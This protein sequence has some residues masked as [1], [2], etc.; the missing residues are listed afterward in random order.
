MEAYEGRQQTVK[1]EILNP[2]PGN[3]RKHDERQIKFFRES[4]K[5][6]GQTRPLLVNVQPVEGVENPIIAGNGIYEAMRREGWDKCEVIWFDMPEHEAIAES[7]RDN[8]AYE[9][10]EI[11][12]PALVKQIFQLEDM[13]Y[14]TEE[15]GLYPEEIES[16]KAQADKGEGGTEKTEKEVID[17][18][19]SFTE[20]L[21]EAHNYLVLYFDDEIT[22]RTAEEVFGVRPVH[23]TGSKPGTKFELVGKGRVIE[24]AKILRMLQEEK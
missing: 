24:G 14:D 7:I 12:V 18:E 22:Y 13:G 21:Y 8:E 23:A 17:G 1:M 10:G 16:M 9:L 3:H 19:V 6:V 15:L 11:D 2:M 4:L 20:E 5:R